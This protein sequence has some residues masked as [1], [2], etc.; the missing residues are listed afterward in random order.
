[1]DITASALIDKA[2]LAADEPRI[3]GAIARGRSDDQPVERLRYATLIVVAFSLVTALVLGVTSSIGVDMEGVGSIAW[4]LAALLV[5][6]RIFR[7]GPEHARISDCVGTLGLAWIGAL[8][9]GTLALLGLRLHFPMADPL[10][11]QADRALHFDAVALVAA[12]VRQGQWIFSLMAPAYAYTIPLL[13]LSMCFLGATGR[14]IEAWRACFCFNGSLLTT[15]LIAAFTPAKG[16]GLYAPPTLLTQLPDHAMVY[17]WP[18]FD[19]F[20][21]GN[22]PV[23]G[24]NAL[25][26]VISFP[27][28]HA[29]MGFIILAMWRSI[30]VAMALACVWLMFMLLSAFTYGGHYLVDVIAGLLIAAGWFAVSRRLVGSD[31]SAAQSRIYA[32]ETGAPS[33]PRPTP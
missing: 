21:A 3:A 19:D 12:L 31:I 26:G 33:L 28:F 8:S 27:S 10:L 32:E 9:G 16:L 11:L 29:A 15:S 13:A 4:L 20:Y 5:I 17:F 7:S 23:L 14:R 22:A 30:R 2:G 24:L 18:K 25:S 1:M 6:S